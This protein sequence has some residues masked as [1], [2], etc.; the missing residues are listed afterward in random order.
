MLIFHSLYPNQNEQIIRL[1][2]LTDLLHD[3]GI[4]EVSLF[5]PYLP[6]SRQDKRHVPGEAL[7]M[8]TV[9]RML[10]NAGLMRLYVVDC[11]FMRG[12][13]H[14]EYDKL[15]ITNISAA[16]LLVSYCHRTYLNN[17][18][19]QT[20]GPDEGAKQLIPDRSF[21]HMFKTRGSY[22]RSA[23]ISRKVTSVA[24]DRISLEYDTVIIVDDIISTGSTMLKAVDALKAKGVRYIYCVSTHGLF[25]GDSYSELAKVV[26]GIVVGDTIPH[27]SSHPI[28]DAL[29]RGAVLP[30]WTS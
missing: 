24:T 14:G 22:E 23:V 12:R 18:P 25:L 26:D 30:H 15:P 19:F 13:H 2:L 11:H 28:V 17:V 16:K 8:H 20:I 29:I 21:Q 6:Y 3:L 4:T 10:A 27:D 7:G 5:C 1:M 9:C